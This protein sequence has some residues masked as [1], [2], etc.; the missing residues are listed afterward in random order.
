MLFM[1]KRSAEIGGGIYFNCR[2]KKRRGGTKM[3][4]ATISNGGLDSLACWGCLGCAA[5]PSVGLLAALSGV[6][7]M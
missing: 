7:V 2:C 3:K 5:C 1:K 6:S 4:K